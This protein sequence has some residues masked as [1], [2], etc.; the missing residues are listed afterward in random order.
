MKRLAL[1]W[2]SPDLSALAL[3]FALLA[4]DG[5]HFVFARALHAVLPP[6]TS[7]LFVMTTATAQVAVF[8]VAK[9]K[10][11]WQTFARH[12]PLFLIVGGLVA[13]STTANYIAVGF[14]DPGTAALLSQ[15]SVLFGLGFGLLWLREQLTRAQLI[16]AA[17]CLTGAAI[18]TFHP[19]DYFRLGSLMVIGSALLYALHAAIVKRQAGQLDF[20][21]FFAWRLISTTGFLLISAALQ[22]GLTWPKAEVW[23]LLIIAGTVDVV[24]SRSL[25]YLSLRRLKIS[26]LALVLTLTPVVTIVWSLLLFGVQPTAQQFVGGAAVLAGVLIVT[27]RRAP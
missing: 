10:L 8:A 16:G 22:G 17:I 2:A 7:V 6:F 25:Y 3:V 21:E 1:A 13:I 4:V 26:L 14:I 24:I 9:G 23:P 18:I 20:V 27:T 11:R 5:L 19:G 15:T 12:A